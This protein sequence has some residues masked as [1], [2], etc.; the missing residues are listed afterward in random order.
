MIGR[1]LSGRTTAG[2]NRIPGIVLGGVLAALVPATAGA[3]DGEAPITERL[4]TA[5]PERG[6][7]IFRTCTACH[8]VDANAPHG[9]GRACGR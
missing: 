5:S 3:A 9:I 2:G 8:A 7:K 6:E 1:G 4:A